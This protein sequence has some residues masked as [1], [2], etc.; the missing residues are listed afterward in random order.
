[1]GFTGGTKDALVLAHHTSSERKLKQTPLDV[2][3][4][5]S[6]KFIVMHSSSLHRSNKIYSH[7]SQ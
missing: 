2:A 5:Y 7:G 6:P 1:M 4:K 3:I